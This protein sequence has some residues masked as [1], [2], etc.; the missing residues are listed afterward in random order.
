METEILPNRLKRDHKSLYTK[1]W[2][3][4]MPRFRAQ[5]RRVVLIG[6]P[7]RLLV[8]QEWSHS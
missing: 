1:P 6:G 8:W 5:G 3:G 2:S 4:T 7:E